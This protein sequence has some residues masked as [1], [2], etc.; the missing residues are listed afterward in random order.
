MSCGCLKMSKGER[1]VTS[2][3][4]KY[5][6]SFDRE[7]IYDDL[8]SDKGFPLRFDFALFNE[9]GEVAGLLE[10]QGIQHYTERPKD[11]E[12]GRQQREETDEKKRQYCR[13]HKIRLFEI[14]YDEH[15]EYA[16]LSVI[17]ELYANPVP[18]SEN[19]EKV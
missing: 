13:A 15:I 16:T 11:K 19:S 1:I 3:L 12:F 8:L 2:L 6:I 17:V 14:K 10:F 18:S 4:R 5:G 9:A 7:Y